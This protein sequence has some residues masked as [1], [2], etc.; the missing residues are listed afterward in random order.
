ME[1]HVSVPRLA[2]PIVTRFFSI[3]LPFQVGYFCIT[4]CYPETQT[5]FVFTTNP[6]TE[7]HEP[8]FIYHQIE[9]RDTDLYL[10]PDIERRELV[11]YFQDAK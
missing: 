10:P 1:S 4:A 11:L 5:R 3:Y 9:G 2:P 6:D 7:G 8:V